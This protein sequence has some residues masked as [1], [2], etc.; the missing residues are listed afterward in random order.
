MNALVRLSYRLRSLATSL[1]RSSGI[2]YETLA[3]RMAY[4]Q[5]ADGSNKRELRKEE[6]RNIMEIIIGINIR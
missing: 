2:S 5:L 3:K 4:F 1:M 6:N